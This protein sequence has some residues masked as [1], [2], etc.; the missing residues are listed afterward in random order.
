MSAEAM[1][2]L[3]SVKNRPVNGHCLLSCVSRALSQ[4]ISFSRGPRMKY[5]RCEDQVVVPPAGSSFQPSISPHRDS[6]A[7][8][9]SREP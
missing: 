3:K 6:K 5:Q 9:S 7:C 1:F 2:H 4:P 8:Q